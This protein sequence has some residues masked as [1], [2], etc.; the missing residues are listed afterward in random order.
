MQKKFP[1]KLFVSVIFWV[2]LLE[3][4]SSFLLSCEFA[5][6]ACYS[7]RILGL[8]RERKRKRGAMREKGKEDIS[9]GIGTAQILLVSCQCIA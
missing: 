6:W 1:K 5:R 4:F 8:E 3:G 7:Y 9:F 2:F